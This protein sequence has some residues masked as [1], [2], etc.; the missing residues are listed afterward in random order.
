MSLSMRR[1]RAIMVKELREYGRNR[2]LVAA[3]AL[4]PLIFTVQPLI[5]I[6][7]APSAA[8]ASLAGRHELSFMLGI[9]ILV[10]AALAAF[11]VAGERQQ[12]TL[13]PVLATPITREEFLLGKALAVFLPSLFIAY[14]VFALFIAVVEL[15]AKPGIAPAL[16]ST[17]DVIVQVLF[18]PLLAAWSIW[19]GIAV[20]TRSNDV[21]VAQQLSVLSSLPLILVTIMLS[22]NIIQPSFELVV[23]LGALL[24]VADVIGWRLIAPLFNREKLIS[25][26]H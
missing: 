16:I 21:R 25:G 1:V 17:D 8:A 14:V 13:E 11:A 20:S 15:F 3:M 26:P 2:S 18:T 9:P 6:F 7:V 22:F 10:P 24:L 4:Y 23:L 5:A 19:V 12:E